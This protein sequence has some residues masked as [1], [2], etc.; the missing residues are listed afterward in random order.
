MLKE[1]FYHLGKLIITLPI[2]IFIR[3]I[4]FDG[5]ENFIKNKPVL[6][7]SNHPNSF[8]DGIVFEYF[9]QRKIYSLTRGDVFAKPL[10]NHIFR[11]ARLLPIF[12]S[13][14]ASAAKA[15]K[16]NNQTFEE[17][18]E[19]F[20]K[21]QSILIFS[22][23]IAKPEK[24]VRKLKKGT[25]AL[26]LDALKRSDYT[27]DIYIVPA[28][29][30]Y[31]TFFTARRSIHV[32]FS[33]PI[34]MLDYVAQAKENELELVLNITNSLEKSFHNEI[35]KT[36]GEYE[37]ERN[38][39]HDMMA[40]DS[41]RPLAFKA[42]DLW[43]PSVAKFNAQGTSFWEKVASYKKATESKGVSDANIANRSFDYLSMFLAIFTFG[44]S[45]PV[46]VLAY[47]IW[48]L[49]LKITEVKVK[50]NVFKDSFIL[51]IGMTLILFLTIG[52]VWYFFAT[53][54]SFWPYI[55][56][57][58]ALYGSLCWFNVFDDLPFLWKELKW[59]GLSNQE[60]TDLV[61]QRQEIMKELY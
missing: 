12:R 52:V 31:Q 42:Y 46:F 26:A 9:Y 18:F 6:I 44:I 8:L 43:K 45:F 14:D 4:H 55:Y 29:I 32:Q 60:K 36:V 47:L 15:R 17:C 49:T 25:A 27:L 13:T 34:R 2:R 33:K 30:N 3:K 35:V 39:A 54:Q 53:K 22:E 16:G 28:A 41:F 7:A 10:V 21:N 56:S 51:G 19:I 20:K 24:D 23:G 38:F 40:N 61:N 59:L 48:Q 58:G 11:S 37:I 57:I 50:N 1:W 5:T